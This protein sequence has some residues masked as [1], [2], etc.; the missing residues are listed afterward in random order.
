MRPLALLVLLLSFTLSFT[1]CP[2][3]PR[4]PEDPIGSP[5]RTPEATPEA[6]PTPDPDTRRD[7]EAGVAETW[8]PTENEVEV[9]LK[10]AAAD[11]ARALA[12]YAMGATPGEVLRDATGASE[13]R[14]E[15]ALADLVQPEVSSQAEVI[16]PQLGG[17]HDDM[18]SVMVVVRQR[19]VDGQGSAEEV[20]RTLDVRMRREDDRWAFSALASGG[21]VPV[22]RPDDVDTWASA[23]LDHERIWLPDSARWDVHRGDVAA[24]LLEVMVALAERTE[25]AVAVISTGHPSRVFGTQRPSNHDRGRAVDIY[26][27]DGRLVVE[28]RDEGGSLYGVARWLYDDVGVPELGSPWSFDGRGGRSF[29]DPVHRDHIHIGTR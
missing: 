12:T 5:Q 10:R 13:Q 3:D 27:V 29:T 15:D 25:Y 26:E 20:T 4:A 8:A 28:S 6:A 23:V 24:E 11:V 14:S 22:P 16:Y 9:E 19:L 1:A 17:M 7:R 18:A 21:G 2:T